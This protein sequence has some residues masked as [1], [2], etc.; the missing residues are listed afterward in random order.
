MRFH[1]PVERMVQKL[2]TAQPGRGGQEGINSGFIWVS[3]DPFILVISV[4]STR[5]TNFL[6]N[7]PVS[8]HF[9][10]EHRL[11]LLFFP[12]S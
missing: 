2:W 7:S 3:C 6:S 12:I 1:A 10:F 4:A 11:C 8:E 9:V 5:V